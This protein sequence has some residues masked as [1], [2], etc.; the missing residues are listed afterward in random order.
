[1]FAASNGH[2]DI[3]E[4]LIAQGANVNNKNMSGKFFILWTII[5][6]SFYPNVYHI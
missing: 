4:Y 2:A 3:V 5:L 1:M 6:L